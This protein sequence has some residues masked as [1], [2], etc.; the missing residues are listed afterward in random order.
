ML[1]K[2]ITLIAL[3]S[4]SFF[5]TSCSSDSKINDKDKKTVDPKENVIPKGY[6]TIG[7]NSIY[8]NCIGAG[9]PTVILESG[10]GSI[11]DYWVKIQELTQTYTQVC[12][13]DRVG[14]GRSSRKETLSHRTGENIVNELKLL[15]DKLYSQNIISDSYVLVGHSMGGVYVRLFA[16][17]YPEKVKGLVLVDATHEEI[18]NKIDMNDHELNKMTYKDYTDLIKK[19][20]NTYYPYFNNKL[21][22]D[23]IEK[24]VLNQKHFQTFKDESLEHKNTVNDLN[25]KMQK[26]KKQL[27]AEKIKNLNYK[28]SIIYKSKSH[29]DHDWEIWENLQKSLQDVY[30]KNK[31]IKSSSDDHNL[32]ITDP[33]TINKEIYEI[34][35]VFKN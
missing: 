12:S 3:M 13:Y 8:Y 27:P 11:A 29:T 16:D 24:L 19:D 21:N 10:F 34:I 1:R 26:Y 2:K 9:T 5:Y 25:I 32:H 4:F 18:Y 33:E 6:I 20:L 7:E 14:I 23:E 28:V 15:L 35:K 31:L 30:P 22:L 17:K